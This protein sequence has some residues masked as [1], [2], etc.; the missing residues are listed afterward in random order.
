MPNLSFRSLPVAFCL[1]LAFIYSADAQ[2]TMAPAPPAGQPVAAG[3]IDA[4][5]PMAATPTAATP[6]APP[7][8]ASAGP[9]PYQLNLLYTGELWN[10][11]QGGL[12]QGTVYMYNAD[13]RLDVDTDKAFGWTGGHFTIEGFY[14][15]ANS[16]GNQYVGAVDQQSP[17]DS[18]CCAMWRLYQ[19]FYDQTWGNTDLR[20]GIYDLETEFSVTKPMSLF[21]S[22]NLTWNTALDQSGTMPQNGLIGPGNYPYTPLALRIRQTFSPEWSVQAVIADG[23]SDNPNHPAQNGVYFSSQYGVLGMGEVDYTPSSHTKVMAGMWG[24][25]SKLPANV[26]NP[27][28]SPRSVWGETG[29]YIGGATRLYSAGG[30]RGLDGFVTLGISSQQSTNVAHSLN[31][32][33]VYTGLFD[34]RPSDKA[35]VSFNVNANPGSY[36]QGQNAQGLGVRFYETSFEATYRAK[37]CSWLTVQPDIQYIIQPYYDPTRKNALVV[38]LHFEIGHLFD[39]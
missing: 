21:L 3:A 34:A 8:A 14:E 16:L 29:G 5:P 4:T 20:L 18:A 24:L 15:S 12:R 25:T 26:P 10:N 31:G 9:S 17:I 19:V 11:S 7:A 37:I 27:D 35:G 30:R 36:R 38:G 22:K 13:G 2:Q 1:L 23:A 6:S 28:G 32:G 33:L 39:L